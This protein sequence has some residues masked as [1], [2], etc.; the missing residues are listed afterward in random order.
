[1]AITILNRY[2]G[3]PLA[4]FPGPTLASVNFGGLNLTNADLSGQDCT[5]A[6]FTGCNVS[7]A[8]FQNANV[9]GATFFRSNVQGADFRGVTKTAATNWHCCFFEDVVLDVADQNVGAWALPVGYTGQSNC[10]STDAGPTTGLPDAS[11]KF[12]FFCPTGGTSSGLWT[13][14]QIDPVTGD[15]GAEILFAQTVKA[16]GFDVGVAKVARG[17]TTMTDWTPPIGAQY[18]SDLLPNLPAYV[19]QM[20]ATWPGK[21][22][23]WSY[24]W[25]LGEDD[26]RSVGAGGT[27]YGDGLLA[28]LIGVSGLVGNNV[29]KWFTC[30][31]TQSW[32]NGAKA[33]SLFDCRRWETQ[34]SGGRI[35]NTDDLLPSQADGVHLTAAG[36]D[37]LGQRWAALWQTIVPTSSP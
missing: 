33:N 6:I 28:F 19:S 17:A 22:S 8:T 16:A 18:V 5:N 24:N 21:F 37:T 3:A 11:I 34:R 9:S 36:Q 12:A 13:A 14:L 1:V 7:G 31:R 35:L 27:L 20:Q 10:Q 23:R 32:L 30:T 26:A 29:W 4:T 25:Y 2:T 15:H